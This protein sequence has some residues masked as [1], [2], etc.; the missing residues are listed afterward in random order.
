MVSSA[1]PLEL[2]GGTGS[3]LENEPGCSKSG[4]CIEVQPTCFVSMYQGNFW[5]E[6]RKSLVGIAW[7]LAR[8][9]PATL[10]LS[11]VDLVQD[12]PKDL[13]FTNLKPQVPARSLV[14]RLL[15]I[16]PGP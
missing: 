4:R 7:G 9:H 5:D 11:H 12:A 10:S 2:F 14:L 1:I 6:G 16:S 15:M 3:P 8:H 13:A